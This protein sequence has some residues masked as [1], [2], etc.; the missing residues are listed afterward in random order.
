MSR[1]VACETL[2]HIPLHCE[3]IADPPA[4]GLLASRPR[5]SQAIGPVRDAAVRQEIRRA[6]VG[7]HLAPTYLWYDGSRNASLVGDKI[8]PASPVVLNAPVGEKRNPSA[9][10]YPFQV[11][12]AVQPYGHR[13]EDPRLA[14]AAGRLLGRFRLVEG[15]HGRYET[16]RIYRTRG[17]MALWRPGC[18]PRFT[19]K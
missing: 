1:A 9:R 10:I 11:H 3:C 16:G 14:Q 6:D 19:T 5:P 7:K 18:I 8:D 15:D 13:E 17:S 12:A 2:C 4:T